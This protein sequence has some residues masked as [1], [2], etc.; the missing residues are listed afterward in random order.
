MAHFR[1]TARGQRSE[2][3]TLGNKESGLTVDANAWD[4]GVQV[5]AWYDDTT[6][7]N[8]FVVSKTGGSNSTDPAEHIATWRVAA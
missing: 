1:G 8:V 2:V 6:N 7:E 3:A 5:R 4:S